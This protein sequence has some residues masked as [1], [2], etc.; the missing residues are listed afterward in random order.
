MKLSRAGITT[1]FPVIQWDAE[2][3][4]KDLVRSCAFYNIATLVIILYF[5]LTGDLVKILRINKSLAQQSC[6]R[7]NYG[8]ETVGSERCFN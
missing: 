4:H 5:T 8:V 2:C 7:S 6:Y 3:R 1:L